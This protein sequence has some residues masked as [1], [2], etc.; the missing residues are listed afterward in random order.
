MTKAPTFRARISTAGASV[1]P[2]TA[3]NCTS[4]ISVDSSRASAFANKVNAI[5]TPSGFAAKASGSS[6][7]LAIAMYV[8]PSANVTAKFFNVSAAESLPAAAK[9]MFNSTPAGTSINGVA[10]RK[11]NPFSSNSPLT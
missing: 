5:S 9:P 7:P 3:I 8:P 6:T 2:W 11:L 10:S 4:S 1:A